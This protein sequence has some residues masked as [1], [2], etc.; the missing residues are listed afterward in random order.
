MSAFAMM[1]WVHTVT[2]QPYLGAGSLG[3]VWG[4]AQVVPC[5]VADGAQLVLNSN[6]DQVVSQ[7]RVFANSANMPLFA[8]GSKVT[9]NA[10]TAAERVARVIVLLN[11]DSGSLHMGAVLEAQLT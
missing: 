6:G 1:Q 9:L 4:T 2:V 7:T 8:N 3:D 5:F 10:G 11:H